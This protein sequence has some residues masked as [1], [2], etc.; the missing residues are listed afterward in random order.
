M[1]PTISWRSALCIIGINIALG[2]CST[3]SQVTTTLQFAE[4]AD[5]PYEN[6]LVIFLA[7][8]FDSRRYLEQEVVKALAERGTHAVASTSLM[9]SRVPV[10]RQ[11]IERLCQG[12]R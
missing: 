12:S 7:D 10:T 11:L 5:A 1:R 8:K 4:S 3:G 9:D 2:A 6:V